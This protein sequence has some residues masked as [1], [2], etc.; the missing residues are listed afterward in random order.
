MKSRVFLSVLVVA[1]ACWT[2]VASF[3]AAPRAALIAPQNKTSVADR[4]QRVENGLLTAVI[5]PRA[6]RRWSFIHPRRP[7]S[8]QLNKIVGSE[9]RECSETFSI[10]R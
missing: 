10:T 9:D 2:L 4:I 1:I 6:D 5:I 3:E 8:S 7:S